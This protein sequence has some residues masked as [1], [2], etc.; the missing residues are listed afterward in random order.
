[1]VV[2]EYVQKKFT[3]EHVLFLSNRNQPEH[4]CKI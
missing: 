1:M 4:K 3:I 2:P